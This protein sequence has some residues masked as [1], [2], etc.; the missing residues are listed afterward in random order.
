MSYLMPKPSLKKNSSGTIL[1]LD[2]RIRGFIP[3]SR[4]IIPKVNVTARLEFELAYCC[5]PGKGH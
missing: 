5:G 3:F 2:G 1:T 4:G